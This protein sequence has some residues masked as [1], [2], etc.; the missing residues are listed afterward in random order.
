MKG[1]SAPLQT[2][3]EKHNKIVSNP[4]DMNID[5]QKMMF[6]SRDEAYA[7]FSSKLIPGRDDLLGVRM[8]IL[9][10]LAKMII[11]EDEWN[12]YLDTWEPHHLEYYLLRAFVISYV[13]VDVDERLSL[14][15]DFIPLIDNWSVCDSFSNTWK[16]KEN[17]K[18]KLWEFILPYLESDDEFRMR[19]AATIMAFHFVDE[20]HVNDIIRSLDTHHN[21][22]YYYKMGAAWTLSV[23]FA[24]FPDITY[25]YMRN[26][27]HLD[28][29]TFNML[30]GKIRDSYRVTDDMKS[31]VKLLKR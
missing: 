7:A 8:P 3:F 5:V 24:K 26:E 9:R 4:C 15:K 28:D 17:E 31:K 23:C 1:A 29:E 14:F 20:Q 21:D 6:K 13:K 30:I 12:E 16:P 25:D 19:Y 11:D 18:E 22:G 2:I 27:N 10:K